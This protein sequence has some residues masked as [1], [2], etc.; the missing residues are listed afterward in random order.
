MNLQALILSLSD[1]P[2]TCYQNTNA[3]CDAEGEDAL[4]ARGSA[5]P[6]AFTADKEP[7][8]LEG[9]VMMETQNTNPLQP[10]VLLSQLLQTSQNVARIPDTDQNSLQQTI[11][12][13]N[14]LQSTQESDQ[15]GTEEHS[16]LQA[17]AVPDPVGDAK[18]FIQEIRES[19]GVDEH[20][21]P[22]EKNMNATD[23][24]QL[25]KMYFFPLR[26]TSSLIS[27]R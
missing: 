21:L 2:T 22:K 7:L 4:A 1:T 10:T 25:L 5:L 9:I 26:P 11:L 17:N 15:M 18:A 6:S 13:G 12:E 16:S 20:G 23:L 14:P 19:R 8:H 27:H 24:K 3:C